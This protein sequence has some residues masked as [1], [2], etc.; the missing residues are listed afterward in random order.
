MLLPQI[1]L[2]INSQIHLLRIPSREKRLKI[3]KMFLS[4][5]FKLIDLIELVT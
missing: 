2:S 5:V 3:E 1:N 4:F